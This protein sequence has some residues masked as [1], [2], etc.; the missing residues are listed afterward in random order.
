MLRRHQAQPSQNGQAISEKQALQIDPARAAPPRTRVLTPAPVPASAVRTLSSEKFRARFSPRVE[1][2]EVESVLRTLEEARHDLMH[3]TAAASLHPVEQSQ[4]D[5][6]IHDTTGDFVAATG[7]PWWAAAVTHDNLIELQPLEILRSRGVLNQTLR[8]EYAHTII[9]I[10]SHGRAPRWLSEGLAA[11]LAGEG[12]KLALEKVD[13]QLSVEELEKRLS[14]PASPEE[15]R[16]L[17]AAAYK[18]VQTLIRTE[19]EASVWRRL[20]QE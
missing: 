18:E 14:R 12:Q 4:L 5:V 13:E 7:Q 15:M 6:V 1:R 3:R 8:H 20:V 11:H 16:K 17:Y 9:D 2:R 19:G 10:L